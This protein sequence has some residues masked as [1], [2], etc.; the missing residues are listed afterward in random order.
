MGAAASITVGEWRVARRRRG[1]YRSG[2]PARALTLA[3]LLAATAA[4]AG[5]VR[6][7]VRFAG[8]A[9]AAAPLEVTK[10][11][12]TCGDTQPDERLVVDA[13][14]GLANVVVSVG[15]LPGVRLEPA[16]I[17]LDQQRCRFAPRVQT[18]P[19]G[20]TL[21]IVNGD[22]V[23]HNVHGWRGKA[24]AF[25]V[26]TPTQGERVPRP[27]PRAGLVRVGCDV[28]AWMAAWVHVAEGPAAVTG[29]DGAFRLAGLPPGKHAVTAWHET[30]GE[31]AAEVTVGASDEARLD[32]TFGG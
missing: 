15:P 12:A 4:R 8:P 6:G 18:A 7:V 23:L 13:A 22:P 32:F 21:E 24:S 27:L 19:V 14:G 9:P 3:L 26:P 31:K 17:V 25:N 29:A 20:S 16:R 28:H 1:R 11:R 5:E 10:D 30:L 2:M